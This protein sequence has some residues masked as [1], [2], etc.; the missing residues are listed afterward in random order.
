MAHSD[1]S[2][3]SPAFKVEAVCALRRAAAAGAAAAHAPRRAA[4]QR[5]RGRQERV[6]PQ[7]LQPPLPTLPKAAGANESVRQPSARLRTSRAPSQ[8]ILRARQRARARSGA[9]SVRD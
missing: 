6:A 7:V 8:L 4:W 2:T 5:V 9:L 1:V 3:S